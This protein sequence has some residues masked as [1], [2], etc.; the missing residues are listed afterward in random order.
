MPQYGSL[1]MFKSRARTICSMSYN[2]IMTYND[3][4]VTSTR[5][6]ELVPYYCFLSTYIYVMLTRTLC[7]HA[8]EL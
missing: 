4:L 7:V 6:D 5:R 3:N 8:I 2:E 1:E